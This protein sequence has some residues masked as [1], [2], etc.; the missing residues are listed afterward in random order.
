MRNPEYS[1]NLEFVQERLGISLMVNP[2][3]VTARA[4]EKSLRFPSAQGIETF[5]H[6]RIQIVAV[7]VVKD[8][9]LVGMRLNHF[10]KV[11][12]TVLVCVVQRSGGVIIRTATLS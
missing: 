10:R 3:L 5:A 7:K 12:G 4:I 1:R 2:E 6:E 11:Y 8:S 9:K